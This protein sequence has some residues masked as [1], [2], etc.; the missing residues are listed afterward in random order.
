MNELQQAY[1]RIMRPIEDC[2]IRSI[3]RIVRNAQDAEDAMQDS[4]LTV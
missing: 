3:W 1:D 4:L 2:M